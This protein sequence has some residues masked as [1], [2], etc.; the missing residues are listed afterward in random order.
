MKTNKYKKIAILTLALFSINSAF[1]APAKKAVPQ[2]GVASKSAPVKAGATKSAAVGDTSSEYKAHVYQVERKIEDDLSAKIK[3]IFGSGSRISV[4]VKATPDESRA[5]SANESPKLTDVGYVPFPIDLS[6]RENAGKSVTNGAFIPLKSLDVK[7]HVA[8]Q[9]TTEEQNHLKAMVEQSLSNLPAKVELVPIKLAGDA[10]VKPEQTRPIVDKLLSALPFMVGSLL[11]FI[12]LIFFAKAFA[13]S[14]KTISEALMAMRIKEDVKHTQTF[15]DSEEGE[16][17]GDPSRSKGVA[18]ASEKV[19]GSEE[20]N[21]HTESY[22]HHLSLFKRMI[23][24]SPIAVM[25]TVKES[26]QESSSE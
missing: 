21:T 7:V 19:A 5:A 8:E 6:N 20:H 16:G 1:A 12:A 2:R 4:S 22:L 24:E 9:L 14:A 18:G 13:L 11:I 10:Y 3:T 25:Q 15:E 23:K 17:S 26:I